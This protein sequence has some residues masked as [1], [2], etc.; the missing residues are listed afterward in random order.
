MLKHAATLLLA[1]LPC[2][3]ALAETGD[4]RCFHSPGA[5]R[6]LRLEFG[7]PPE[8]AKTAYVRYENGSADILLK[9]VKSEAAETMPGRPMEFTTTW[10]EDLPG[11]GTYTVV[12]QGARVYGFSYMRA[13]DRKN[14]AFEEDLEAWTESGCRWKPR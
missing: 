9:L 2:A 11:G 1:G 13:K 12:S 5:G 6:P 4:I 10:K 7:F 14:F 3:M 8:G